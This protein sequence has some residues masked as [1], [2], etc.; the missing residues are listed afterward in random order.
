MMRG[1]CLP[2]FVFYSGSILRVSDR[3]LPNSQS[4]SEM[5]G[6]VSGRKKEG[7]LGHQFD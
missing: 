6:G 3:S 4:F 1:S 7:Q 5:D 2:Y